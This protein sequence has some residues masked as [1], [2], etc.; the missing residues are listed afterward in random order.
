MF[1]K[2]VKC[3]ER[4]DQVEKLFASVPVSYRVVLLFFVTY[5][6]VALLPPLSH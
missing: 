6:A 3:K 1:T 4:Y 2:L 5:S